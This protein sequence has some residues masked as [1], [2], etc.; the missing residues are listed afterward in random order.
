MQALLVYMLV[1]LQEG[2][3]EWNDF[4]GVLLNTL[5]V[6]NTFLLAVLAGGVADR[7]RILGV[8]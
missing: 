3:T 5:W 6:S 7:D 8:R 2:E 1:R 4:D